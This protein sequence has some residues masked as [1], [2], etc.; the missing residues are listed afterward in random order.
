MGGTDTTCVGIRYSR[1]WDGDICSW[2]GASRVMPRQFSYMLF[3]S[4]RCVKS[5][6]MKLI[7]LVLY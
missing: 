6:H 3:A 2:K 1:E 4:L 7:P 5:C